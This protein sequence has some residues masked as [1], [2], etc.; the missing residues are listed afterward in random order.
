MMS[1][2]YP[3]K[4][5]GYFINLIKALKGNL[6]VNQMDTD[7]SNITQATASWA[8]RPMR[9]NRRQ[10]KRTHITLEAREVRKTKEAKN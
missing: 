7:Q 2:R 8:A 3:I 5:A 10:A 6:I 9:R 4:A 1:G